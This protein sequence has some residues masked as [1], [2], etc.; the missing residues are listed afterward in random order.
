LD[1]HSN[2]KWKHILKKLSWATWMWDAFPLWQPRTLVTFVSV[3]QMSASE[4]VLAF[5][6]NN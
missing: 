6:M 1:V 5:K 4:R 2:D 3:L